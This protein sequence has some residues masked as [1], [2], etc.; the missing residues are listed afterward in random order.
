[1]KPNLEKVFHQ[2]DW[3]QFYFDKLA[4]VKWKEINIEYDNL[5]IADD[6]DIP[7]DIELVFIYLYRDRAREYLHI[8]NNTHLAGNTPYQL[9]SG[10]SK[11]IT[12]IT[13]GQDWVRWYLMQVG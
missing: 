2:A 1:M 12:S 3:K 13:E 10:R 9:L 8:I 11:D 5:P 7:H 4:F 6:I